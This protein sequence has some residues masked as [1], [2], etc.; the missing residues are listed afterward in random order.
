MK[1]WELNQRV[2]S[3]Y[4]ASEQKSHRAEIPNTLSV[5]GDKSDDCFTLFTCLTVAMTKRPHLGL[6]IKNMEF[7]DPKC[8]RCMSPLPVFL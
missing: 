1:T 3:I 4:L 8:L 7:C 5:A 2:L 6:W